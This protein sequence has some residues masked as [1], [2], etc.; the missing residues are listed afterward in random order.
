MNIRIKMTLI[1]AS[2]VIMLTAAFGI[3]FIGRS[4]ESYE[5]KLAQAGIYLESRDYDNAIA[6]YNR[7]I[8][9]NKEC[10]EAYVGLSDAYFA[11]NKTEKALEILKKGAERTDGDDIVID[12]M[13]ELFPDYQYAD[14]SD[15]DYDEDGDWDDE[16]GWDDWDN[17][18]L[19]D[20]EEDTE[21][22][23]EISVPEP[24]V[25]ET[26]EAVTTVPQ[27]SETDTETT[28]PT[29]TSEAVTTTTAAPVTTTAAPV[30]A[31]TVPPT[32]TAPPAT[33]Q[34]TARVTTVQTT[35]AT[36]VQ[37]TA[38]TTVTATEALK[39]VS[40]PDFTV[41]TLDEAYAWCSKNNVI[42]SVVGVESDSAEILSQSPAPDS[43]VKENSSIIVVLAE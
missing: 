29:T 5:E 4:S 19:D 21:T 2:I 36:T 17:G 26:M 18:L 24:E 35:A 32:V 7:I 42:L 10:A 16:D 23:A 13:N 27:E 34:P 3:I 9:E 39:D 28:V 14:A 15:D 11:K 6:I 40:V 43:T 41:M 20:F 8:S 30:I 12:K 33:T 37:T 31:T 1:A 25:S 38:A 22:A